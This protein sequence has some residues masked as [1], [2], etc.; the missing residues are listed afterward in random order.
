VRKVW[1]TRKTRRVLAVLADPRT[2]GEPVSAARLHYLTRYRPGTL[3]PVLD[4]LLRC[5]WIE[6]ASQYLKEPGYRITEYGVLKVYHALR[7]HG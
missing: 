2:Y 3:Y 5:G 6:P 4:E 7:R 1:T